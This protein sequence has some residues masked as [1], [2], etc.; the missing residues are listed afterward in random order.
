MS[1]FGKV[2]TNPVVLGGGAIIGLV[3]LMRAPSAQAAAQSTGFNPAVMSSIVAMNTAALGG[4]IESAAINA[5]IAKAQFARDTAQQGQILSYM[6]GVN[7]NAAAVAI[8][9]IQT[10]AGVTNNMI[11][12]STALALDIQQNTNRLALGA[13]ETDRTRINADKDIQVARYQYKGQKAAA[14]SGAIGS[15]AG[16]ASKIA[17]GL[18]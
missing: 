10:R 14:I 7:E 2:L 4:A 1:Q 13:Q 3:L 12:S 9:G 15:V 11:A 6:K 16:A 17:G 5:E 18:F 8:T